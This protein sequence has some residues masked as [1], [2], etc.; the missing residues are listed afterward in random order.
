M[1][2]AFWHI[3]RVDIEDFGHNIF[4]LVSCSVDVILTKRNEGEGVESRAH[5]I[6]IGNIEFFSQE[7]PFGDE[8]KLSCA[9]CHYCESF[10]HLFRVLLKVVK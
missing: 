4:Y 2:E 1:M 5:Q 3:E 6:E 10:E 8:F 7:I 9:C